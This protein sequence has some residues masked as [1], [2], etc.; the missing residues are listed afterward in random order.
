[1]TAKKGKKPT[2][3]ER[4]H[5]LTLHDAMIRE[6][7]TKFNGL[8]NQ[9]QDFFAVFSMFV[10]LLEKEDEFAEYIST[11]VEEAKKDAIKKAETSDITVPV[12]K[13]V[14]DES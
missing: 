12:N 3:K 7:G 5:A 13:V 6:I 9:V 2:N 8:H 1:M 4:D 14:A 10:E 11:K